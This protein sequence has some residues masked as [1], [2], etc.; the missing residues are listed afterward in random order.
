MLTTLLT[1]YEKNCSKVSV[2]PTSFL[3]AMMVP[4]TGS[5]TE[6]E[7][8]YVQIR[9]RDQRGT[10]VSNFL[11]IIDVEHAHADSIYS[12]SNK[13]FLD[14]GMPNWKET[15]VG[16]SSDGASVDIGVNNSVATKMCDEEHPYI[17]T[18]HC[19][20]HWRLLFFMLSRRT[21]C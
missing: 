5:I 11:K 18:V 14:V 6:L 12:A 15:L 16:A 10:P 8:V 13:A 1:N 9:S 19:V 3:F 20:A 17:L 21:N 2:P 4:L 7:I